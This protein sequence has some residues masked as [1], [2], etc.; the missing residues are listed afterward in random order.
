MLGIPLAVARFNYRLA[1]LPFQLVEDLGMSQLREGSALRLAYERALIGCDL[2]A[3]RL[4]HDGS[5]ASRARA[6]RERNAPARITV[7]RRL[8]VAEQQ[9]QE[10]DAAAAE[11]MHHQRERFLERHRAHTHGTR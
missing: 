6:L 8:V 2:A 11:R 10:E 9:R 3:A 7:A 5:A 1:S 4:L